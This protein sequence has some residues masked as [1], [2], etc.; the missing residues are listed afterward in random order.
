MVL[1]RQDCNGASVRNRQDPVNSC[2]LGE[3]CGRSDL[4]LQQSGG[5][6]CPGDARDPPGAASAWVRDH[7]DC[8][9]AGNG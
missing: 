8:L 3:A 4:T 5:R 2:E 1:C 6:G 7:S 9:R